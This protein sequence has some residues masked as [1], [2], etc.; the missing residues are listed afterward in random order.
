MITLCSFHTQMV[1]TNYSNFGAW[2]SKKF[3]I[4]AFLSQWR[5]ITNTK[6]NQIASKRQQ[7]QTCWKIMLWNWNSLSL[8]IWSDLVN[9]LS[10]LEIFL[11][12]IPVSVVDS[13]FGSMTLACLNHLSDWDNLI[14]FP[15][16]DLSPNL[17]NASN[18]SFNAFLSTGGPLSFLDW[19]SSF[20][21][22]M[23]SSA[24][25]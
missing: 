19:L 4:A 3:E 13:F 12:A 5:I 21:L 23:V 11:K 18:C 15:S 8:H 2:S 1:K 25:E 17:A 10:Y 16:A 7:F 24:V 6:A 22:V 9:F 14:V 20:G